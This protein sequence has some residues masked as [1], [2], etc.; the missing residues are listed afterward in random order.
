MTEQRAHVIH[1]MRETSLDTYSR[2][3]LEG[4]GPKQLEVYNAI[5]ELNASGLFPTDQEV[6][7][8]LGYEDPNK[9]RPRRYEVMKDKLIVE[10][11]KRVCSITGAT[12]LTWKVSWNTEGLTPECCPACESEHVGKYAERWYCGRCGISFPSPGHPAITISW[13]KEGAE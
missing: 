6:T 12:V 3:K 9:V 13:K 4:L 10:A 11:G 7:K 5:L 1:D 8:H 2:L